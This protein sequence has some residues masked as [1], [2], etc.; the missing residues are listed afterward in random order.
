[1]DSQGL[2]VAGAAPAADFVDTLRA[3]RW[4]ASSTTG[5]GVSGS[6]S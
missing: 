6:D 3:L 2:I 1:V 4:R 5:S